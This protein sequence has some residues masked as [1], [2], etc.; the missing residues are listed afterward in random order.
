[1]LF[2]RP[3]PDQCRMAATTTKT[4]RGDLPAASGELPRQ[5]IG[6]Q[7]L[8]DGCAETIP[9]TELLLHVIVDDLELRFHDACSRAWESAWRGFHRG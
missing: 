4:R 6:D 9:P 1:M 3:I 5:S 8:C 7:R 2:S